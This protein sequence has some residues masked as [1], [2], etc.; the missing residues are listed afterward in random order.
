MS[1]EPHSQQ[2]KRYMRIRVHDDNDFQR[3][4]HLIV[5]YIREPEL[6]LSVKEFVF[7]CPSS[8]PVFCMGSPEKLDALQAAVDA[9]DISQEHPI[10]QKIKD[11]GIEE[12]ERSR[13]VRALTWMKPEVVAARDGA[14]ENGVVS[15]FDSQ[16]MIF[17]HYAAALLLLLCPNVEILKYEEGS[18]VIEDI[19]RRNNYS[20]LPTQ[21]L[22]KLRDVTFLPTTET[23]LG[24][25]EYYI[26]LDILAVMRLFHRLPAIESVSV[27]AVGP[28]V[29]AGYVN[30]FPPA[31]SNLKRIY[32]GHSMYGSYLIGTLIGVS[33]RLEE[34]T[35]TIGGRESLSGEFVH[36][37]AHTIGKALYSH[38]S[39]LRK[40]DLD[41]DGHILCIR[42]TDDDDDYDESELGKDEWYERDMEIS[43]APIRAENTRQYGSTIG[44]MHDFESLTHL[45]IG[46]TALLGRRGW[47][48]E[49]LDAPFRLGE[50]LPKSLEYLLIRGYE[51]GKVARYDAQIDE[52]LLSRQD[53]L[54]ALK[55]LHGI[56]ETIPSAKTI[57]GMNRNRDQLWEPEVSNEEW[58]EAPGSTGM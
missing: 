8:I 23:I 5:D 29:R 28:D 9:R 39:S 36:T 18:K 14:D 11:L 19:L 15:F 16:N 3:L 31:T 54:P 46:I 2:H 24:S 51:R 45:S 53:R 13:W 43:T 20:L 55:G 38:K 30:H 25:L 12:P 42:P 49:G 50:A 7:R 37:T 6:A 22:Q 52:F 41:I 10:S 34:F 21:H 35:F 1:P 27:D 32:V 17:A 26:H 58:A 56:D 47:Y 57:Y 4:Y 40:I 44:S 33:K 48:D